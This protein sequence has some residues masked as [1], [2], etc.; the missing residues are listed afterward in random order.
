MPELMGGHPRIPGLLG[1]AGEH[2]PDAG[3]LQPAATAGTE[4]DPVRIRA[5]VA[6]S[7]PQVRRERPRARRAEYHQSS[8]ARGPRALQRN[9]PEDRIPDHVGREHVHDHPE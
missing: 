4:P 1:T 8:F 9:Q 3:V 6:A 2:E 5:W 7:G